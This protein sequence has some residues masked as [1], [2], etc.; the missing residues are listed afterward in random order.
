M[1]TEMV[2]RLYTALKGFNLEG[3]L[4][5]IWSELI[6]VHQYKTKVDLIPT[7]LA[8]PRNWRDVGRISQ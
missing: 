5:A 6:G 1:K 4:L 2:A 8:L 7:E 3:N